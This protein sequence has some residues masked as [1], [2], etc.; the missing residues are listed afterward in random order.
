MEETQEGVNESERKRMEKGRG[1]F[2]KERGRDREKKKKCVVLRKREGRMAKGSRE[3]REGE[4]QFKSSESERKIPAASRV[5]RRGMRL[6]GSK[7]TCW[8]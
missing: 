2:K 6:G 5:Q 7:I 4:N 8:T 1:V 3:E